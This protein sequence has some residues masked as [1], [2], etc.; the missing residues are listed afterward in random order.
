MDFLIVLLGWLLAQAAMLFALVYPQNRNFQKIRFELLNS[1]K[2]EIGY[3]KSLTVQEE[4][5]SIGKY[6]EFAHGFYDNAVED[7]GF[8]NEDVLTNLA[9][10]YGTIK[11]YHKNSN[12]FQWTIETFM[13]S[14]KDAKEMEGLKDQ[15]E[16]SRKKHQKEISVFAENLIPKI[17]KSIDAIKKQKIYLLRY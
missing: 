16:D 7:L 10:H 11:V 1:L 8:L 12:L 15:F 13:S 14:G 9:N 5:D 6:F 17:S 3:N 2:T 4:D